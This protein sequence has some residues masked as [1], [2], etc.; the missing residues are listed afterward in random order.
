MIERGTNRTELV[1]GILFIGLC[2]GCVL[3]VFLTFGKSN[4]ETPVALTPGDTFEVGRS[5]K[6]SEDLKYGGLTKDET[7]LILYRTYD[8]NTTLLVPAKTGTTFTEKETTYRVKTL[9]AE[10]ERLVLV[11]LIPE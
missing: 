1:F 9:D 5:F 8:N 11:K 4:N 2:L 10:T 3:Y 7:S 6:T